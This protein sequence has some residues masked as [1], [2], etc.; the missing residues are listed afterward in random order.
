MDV[1]RVSMALGSLVAPGL[2][3]HFSICVKKF[4]GEDRDLQITRKFWVE[5]AVQLVIMT[6]WDLVGRKDR[7]QLRKLPP[8]LAKSQS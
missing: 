7:S 6:L 5:T 3:M 8:A 2:L 4:V 1:T